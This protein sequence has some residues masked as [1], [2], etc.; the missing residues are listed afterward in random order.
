MG[1]FIVLNGEHK[2]RKFRLEDGATIVIGRE[3]ADLSF[4]DSRMSRRH[5]ELQARED[6]DYVKDL[7]ATNGTWLNDEK[8]KEALLEPG[9]VV[10]IGYTEIEFLGL[11]EHTS[12]L[13]P[14]DA[15]PPDISPNKT[16]AFRRPNLVEKPPPAR[17]G[18]LRGKSGIRA[19]RQAA[20]GKGV[21][22]TAHRLISAK[23]KFCEACGEAI[24]MRDGA[25]DEGIVVESVYLCRMCALISEKQKELGQDLLPSYA[26]IVSGR[27]PGGAGHAGAA[28]PPPS[29]PPM[30]IVEE[31]VV[32]LDDLGPPAGIEVGLATPR[33]LDEAAPAEEEGSG[34]GE[35]PDEKARSLDE[36]A[37]PDEVRFADDGPAGEG[38]PGGAG[39]G[40]PRENK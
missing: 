13:V 31:E 10:R 2:G 18:R 14:T 12:A 32:D 39:G 36:L 24:F 1:K 30:E 9:A 35:A 4:P 26:K 23:G 20:M 29:G 6:G 8:I 27:M 16:I 34:G 33:V 37:L 21:S 17:R 40:P 3:L 38:E 5:C 19:A 28:Q 25:V 15:A 22:D 7:G 11:P